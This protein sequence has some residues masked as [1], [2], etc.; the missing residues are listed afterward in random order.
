[1]RIYQ[2]KHSCLCYDYTCSIVLR[3]VRLC[4]LMHLLLIM[5]CLYCVDMQGIANLSDDDTT[6]DNVEAISS[7]D[8]M[9]L[10]IV[11]DLEDENL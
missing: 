10:H 11:I 3:A 6:N 4:V 2:A 5:S 8:G 1:M 7:M 9:Y